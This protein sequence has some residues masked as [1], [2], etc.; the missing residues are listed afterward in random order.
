MMKLIFKQ[1][2]F[3]ILDSYNVYSENGNVAYKVNGQLAVKHKLRIYDPQGN[4]LGVV[5]EKMVS[6]TPT[7][8]LYENGKK[9]GSI[10]K[11]LFKL[12]GSSYSMDSL[13]WTAKGNFIEWDYSIHDS[14]GNLVAKIGKQILNLTD[15]YVLD[16]V[17]PQDALH[18][19]M[20]VIAVDAEKCSRDKK[21]SN[22][23]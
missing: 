15:T 11:K 7:F 6:I 8:D 3:S 2:M 18:V 20:F 9:I 13:G 23:D 21:N 4:E 22:R 10:K 19:L 14:H 5:N 16:I 12:I 1:K 17:N